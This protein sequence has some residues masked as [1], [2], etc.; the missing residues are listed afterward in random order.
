MDDIELT[1]TVVL[2]TFEYIFQINKPKKHT[3]YDW[4]EAELKGV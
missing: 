1:I 3:I 2:D 4:I